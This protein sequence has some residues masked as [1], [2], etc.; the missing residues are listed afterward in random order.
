M[1]ED[2]HFKEMKLILEYIYTKRVD[3][4]KDKINK[5]KGIEVVKEKDEKLT[6]KED[7]LKYNKDQKKV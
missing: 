2:G 6:Y 7:V 5:L 1:I 4:K 3:F